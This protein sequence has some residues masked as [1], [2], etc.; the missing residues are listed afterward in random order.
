MLDDGKLA[1]GA[2]A[3]AIIGEGW[4]Y[5]KKPCVQAVAGLKV[6]EVSVCFRVCPYATN[7]IGTRIQ[8]APLTVKSRG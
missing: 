8:K 3:C 7:D 2:S 1:H 4:P 6:A 5:T